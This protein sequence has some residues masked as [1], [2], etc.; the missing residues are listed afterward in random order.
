MNG[1]SEFRMR[2]RRPGGG[3][4]TASW[5]RS[6]IGPILIARAFVFPCDAYGRVALDELGERARETSCTRAPSLAANARFHAWFLTRRTERA[7]L[8][9]RAARQS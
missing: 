3:Q 8:A 7:S 5:A 6:L 4:V 2:W 9:G 1:E